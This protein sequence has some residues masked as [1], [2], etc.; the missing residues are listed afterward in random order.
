MLLS[1]YTRWAAPL[2]WLGCLASLLVW[3]GWIAGGVLCVPLLFAGPG[4]LRGRSYTFAWLSLLSLFYMA[5]GMT[6]AFSTP[7]DR[8][9]ATL[10]VLAAGGLFLACVLTN[11]LRAVERRGQ[12]VADERHGEPPPGS[13]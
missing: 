5:L 4:L 8:A 3:F 7:A 2:C 10:H 12:Q 9:I 1:Q 13:Q 11:R 6:E